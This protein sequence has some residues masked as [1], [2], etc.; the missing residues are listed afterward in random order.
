[1]SELGFSYS[2]INNLTYEELQ[3]FHDRI[4]DKIYLQNKA[5]KDADKKKNTVSNEEFEQHFPVVNL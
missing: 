1:M 5:N 2:E 3:L 4:F